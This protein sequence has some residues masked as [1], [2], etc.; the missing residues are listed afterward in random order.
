M[1]HGRSADLIIAGQTDPD[2]ELSPLMDF[3]ERLALESGRPVLVVP[4]IGR[5]PEIGRNVVDRL[6]ARARGG[7]RRLRRTADP[8]A[9]QRQV[10]ILEI[11]E[12]GRSSGRLGA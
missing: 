11:K 5:Y 12:G 9:A 10:Q 6:E 7:A 3:A 8:P 2:W 1:D 4:Y